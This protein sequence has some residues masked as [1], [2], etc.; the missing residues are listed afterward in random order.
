MCACILQT[1]QKK[2]SIVCSPLG[3]SAKL[4]KEVD[5]G[6]WGYK[7]SNFDTRGCCS[8][9]T[10]LTSNNKLSMPKQQQSFTILSKFK[11]L[12][13]KCV[14][15]FLGGGIFPISTS[16]DRQIPTSAHP[17]EQGCSQSCYSFSCNLWCFFVQLSHTQLISSTHTQR[18]IIKLHQKEGKIHNTRHHCSYSP[19]V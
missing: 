14:Y 10:S 3:H 19:M 16:N 9:A 11:V 18:H 5:G 8:H 12:W 6:W 17:A 4:Q 1:K 2:Q 7:V 15:S 13:H